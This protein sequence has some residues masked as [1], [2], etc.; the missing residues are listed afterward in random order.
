MREQLPFLSIPLLAVLGLEHTRPGRPQ[1]FDL[2]DLFRL[3]LQLALFL[4]L[5]LV[6]SHMSPSQ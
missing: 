5:L 2:T 3:F 4:D 6:F 1:R